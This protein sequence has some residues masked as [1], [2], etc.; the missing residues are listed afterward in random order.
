MALDFFISEYLK[1]NFSWSLGCLFSWVKGQCQG[2]K[3]RGD[4]GTVPGGGSV[5]GGEGCR[6]SLLAGL[7]FCLSLLHSPL[8]VRELITRTY[9]SSFRPISLRSARNKD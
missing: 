6:A 5:C 2:C 9:N 8:V 7:P 4:P 3:S 1:V